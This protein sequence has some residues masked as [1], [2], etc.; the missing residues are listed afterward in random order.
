MILM[1]T[2]LTRRAEPGEAHPESGCA[3]PRSRQCI[4][5]DDVDRMLV[6]DFLFEQGNCDR[7]HNRPIGRAHCGFD[8]LQG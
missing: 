4:R 3:H 6:D 1:S 2:R 7:A 5:A 8:P